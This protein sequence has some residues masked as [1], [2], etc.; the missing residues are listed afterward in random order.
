MY[1]R[2]KDI[3]IIRDYFSNKPVQTGEFPRGVYTETFVKACNSMKMTCLL[4][5]GLNYHRILTIRSS[6]HPLLK[7]RAV[8][9]L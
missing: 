6:D 4:C 9:Y 5:S 1:L 7:Y 3:Q 8:T 2:E